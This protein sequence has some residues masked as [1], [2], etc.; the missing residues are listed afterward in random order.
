ME[1]GS[2]PADAQENIIITMIIVGHKA[3]SDALTIWNVTY[4]YYTMHKTDP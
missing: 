2:G 1:M 4:Y 3:K